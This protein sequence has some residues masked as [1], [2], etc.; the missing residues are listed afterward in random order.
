MRGVASDIV[1]PDI[2]DSEAFSFYTHLAGAIA[3]FVGLIVLVWRAEG[4]L[5]TA[6]FAVYG[7]SLT[8]L[9]TSSSLH[10]A[11]HPVSVKGRS[12]LRRMD[13]IAIYLL[14]AGTYTPICLLAVP[15]VWGY[16]VLAFVW[17][18]GL[19]GIILKIFTP[20]APRWVTVG[21]YVG[22]GWLVVIA[23]KPLMDA[24]PPAGLWLLGGGGIT[25]TVGAVVY[26]MKRPDPFP[27]VVGFH[28]FWHIFVLVAAALHFAF[29]YA[30][31][32]TS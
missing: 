32:P 11:I 17:M 3:A 22:M 13:H 30:Y 14:I 25:Y 12:A 31:V 9:F 15:P 21:L 29:V 26:A 8:F 4:W 19:V 2:N 18:F 6:A 1:I 27:T 24:I 10:H 7:A 28:G 20:F 23:I 16:S 5:A